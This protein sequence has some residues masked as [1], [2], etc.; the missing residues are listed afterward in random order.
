MHGT[1]VPLDNLVVR[2]PAWPWTGIARSHGLRLRSPVRY[3]KRLIQVLGAEY[4]RI[5]G[6]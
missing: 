3:R 6:A 1:R 2:A 4:G 5:Q